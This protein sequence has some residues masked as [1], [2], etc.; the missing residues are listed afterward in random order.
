MGSDEEILQAKNDEW[1]E[2]VNSPV[3]SDAMWAELDACSWRSRE[4]PPRYEVGDKVKALISGTIFSAVIMFIYPGGRT[5]MINTIMGPG[6]V[7]ID[8]IRPT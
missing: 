3:D 4:L 2:V 8:D 5:F 7:S 6:K 1:V